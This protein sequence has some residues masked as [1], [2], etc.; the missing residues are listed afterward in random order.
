MKHPLDSLAAHVGTGRNYDCPPLHLWHPQLSGDIPIHISEQGIWYHEGSKIER[1]ALVRLFASIL[2]KEEDG[3]YY[4][5]SPVEKWRIQVANHPLRITDVDHNKT[6]STPTLDAILN[7]DKRIPISQRHPLFLDPALGDIA[8][9]S[10]CHGLT[11]LC[12][13]AAWYRLVHLAVPGAGCVV[14]KSGNYE[15][16]LSTV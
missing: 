4:L 7:T 10:L 3:E 9:I 1:P 13:R 8:G 15:F 11:A 2:R 12:T 14:L 16:R 6:N 5:V